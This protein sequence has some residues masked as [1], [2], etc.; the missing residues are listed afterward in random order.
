MKVYTGMVQV[1]SLIVSADF[2][3]RFWVVHQP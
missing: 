3:T 1:E 2:Y